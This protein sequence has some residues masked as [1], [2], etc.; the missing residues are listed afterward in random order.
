MTIKARLLLLAVSATIL[1][2][3][4]AL[5]GWRGLTTAESSISEIND[6]RLPS[7]IGLQT[8]NEA[9]TNIR[10]HTIETAIWELD[11][12]AVAWYADTL[13]RKENAWQTARKGLD[14]YAPLPQT[15]EEAVLWKQFEKEWAEWK[16]V[17]T[18]LTH[19]MEKLAKPHSEQEQKNVFA[20]FYRLYELQRPLFNKSEE[21]LSKVIQLNLDVATQSGNLAYAYSEQSKFIMITVIVIGLLVLGLLALG[22]I[23]SVLAAIDRVVGS[24]SQVAITQ[25]FKTRLPETADEF[26]ALN[27]SFNQLLGNL[28]QSISEANHVV[29]AIANADF[30]QRMNGN[31]VGDLAVL[32]QGV[33]ASANSVSFMMGELEK[34]MQGL[35]AGKFDVQMDQKV[36][37][38]FRDLVEQ[39]LHAVSQ[40]VAE[41]NA[42][43][44]QM[45]AGNFDARVQAKAQGD[46]LVLKNAIND[47]M[48]NTAKVIASIVAVVEAQALGDLTSELAMG[49]Y[50]G[51]FHDL[52]NAMNYSAA[53]VKEVVVLTV[54][55]SHIVSEAAGQVSQGSAD[56]SGRVQEQAAALEETSSTMNEMAAAVQANTANAR[57]VA[58]LTNQVQNQATDGVQVM[59]QT[60]S[61][62]Q[63]IKA[64]SN[65]ISDIVTIIDSIA[66]QTN[67]LALNAAVEAARA[68]EHGRGFAV[69]ASEVRALAGKSAD[70][71]KDIKALITD[72]VTRIEN[73]TQLADKSGEM[74]NGIAGSIHQVASMIDQIATASNEQS[75]GISQVHLAIADIDKVTQESAALVEETTAAAESLSTEANNLRNDMAFFKTGAATIVSMRANTVGANLNVRPAAKPSSRPALPASKKANNQEWGEF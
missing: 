68:G 33:N 67:L 17:D 62:M 69:V 21:T 34:V 18:K 41:I 63:S 46:L 53:K 15:K 42:I 13:K 32:K 12:N 27:Q 60:I 50:E 43:M 31:Y 19:E 57:K 61:A 56:L 20:E 45:T 52:K 40:V 49:R 64:S 26:N 66:F 71:A 14:I 75:V 36:P 59:Q 28:D 7:L 44:T 54:A 6:V 16:S 37:L 48:E 65:K 25:T 22:V 70:A 39:A 3:I 11:Y 2:L 9:Q 1:A 5:T 74:L 38:A 51:Q 35:N 72:S 73:G 8:L 10:L 4:I 29:G 47:S 58:D 30:A 23:R 24:V 55:S